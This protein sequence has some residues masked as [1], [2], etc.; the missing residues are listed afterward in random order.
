MSLKKNQ[1]MRGINSL[2]NK[3]SIIQN[4]NP[5]NSINVKVYSFWK[6]IIRKFQML[7]PRRQF[8]GDSYTTSH[9]VHKNKPTT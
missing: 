9:F 7:S 1:V 5:L 4:E 6:N 2:A 3:V 8:N